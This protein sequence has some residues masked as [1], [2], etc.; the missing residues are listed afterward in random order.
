MGNS[1]EM[2]KYPETRYRRNFYTPQGWW[3]KGRGATRIK[4]SCNWK[5]ELPHGA[6]AF[7]WEKKTLLISPWKAGCQGSKHPMPSSRASLLLA[8]GSGKL[9][10]CSPRRS[11]AQSKV[12]FKRANSPATNNRGWGSLTHHVQPPEFW[13]SAQWP[14]WILILFP[15][16]QRMFS[17]IWREEMSKDDI[18]DHQRRGAISLEI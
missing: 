4:K 14:I 18:K 13:F 15:Q 9:S 11:R 2:T 17:L 7:G 1:Q 6:V 16:S 8:H 5:Q 3:D 10:W 12:W